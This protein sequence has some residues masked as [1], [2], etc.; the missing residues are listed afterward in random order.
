M[1]RSNRENRETMGDVLG[2]PVLMI[3][4]LFVVIAV[5]CFVL[6]N[7]CYPG[8]IAG[9]VLVSMMISLVGTFFLVVANRATL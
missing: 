1:S 8:D 5:A 7:S 3:V 2:M 9:K 4:L 6:F